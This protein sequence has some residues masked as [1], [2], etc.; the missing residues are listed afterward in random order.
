MPRDF[1]IFY[2]ENVPD[3]ISEHVQ[4]MLQDLYGL[5]FRMVGV[6]L[7]G[8]N[9]WNESARAYEAKSLL[10]DAIGDG[11]T[12]FLWIIEPPLV[13]DNVKVFGYAE[14]IK[15]T[16][17]SISKMSTRTLASKEAAFQ[18]GL[19]LGLKECKNECLMS[20]ADSFETLIQKPSNLCTSC[21][22]QYSRLKIRYA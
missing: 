19:V 5:Q 9:A 22:I 16:I 1:K 17:Y 13:V 14:P 15:G 21:N 3:E 7:P 18:V 2:G 12:F 4:K 20:S 11:I 8:K 10:N 6:R